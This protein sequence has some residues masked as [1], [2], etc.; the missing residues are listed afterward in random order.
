MGWIMLGLG[1]LAFGM[2]AWSFYT[3][4]RGHRCRCPGPR[5][6]WRNPGPILNT[7]VRSRCWYNLT[8]LPLDEKGLIPCPE[9]GSRLRRRKLMRDGRRFRWGRLGSASALIAITVGTIAW[10]Q[11]SAWTST[12]PNLPL[13]MLSRTDLG[14]HRSQVRKELDERVDSNAFDAYSAHLLART[15]IKDLRDDSLRW[16]ANTAIDFLDRL[17]PHSREVL[18]QELAVGDGQSRVVAARILRSNLK[19]PTQALIIASVRELGDDS[20]E[21]GWYLRMGN[22]SQAAEYLKQ[23]PLMAREHVVA[24]LDSDDVQQRLFAA[25]ICGYCGFP[26]AMEPAVAILVEHLHDNDI[27]RDA[28]IASAA[29]YNFGPDAAPILRRYR[30]VEDEQAR[31][32]VRGIIERLENLEKRWSDCENRLPKITEQT[33]DPLTLPFSSVI[34]TR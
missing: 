20:G 32:L 17:W 10:T 5:F 30:D 31:Q 26:E 8:G 1:S 12:L 33:H 21:P 6:S 2:L 24:A 23:W 34:R 9:C 25:A 16:N 14:K 4:P 3:W 7:L 13:V 27:R 28:K 29:L 19:K 18:E 11:G 15:F 22:S